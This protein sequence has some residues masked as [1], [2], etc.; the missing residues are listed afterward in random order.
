MS[1]LDAYKSWVE[2]AEE[3][4]IARDPKKFADLAKCVQAWMNAWPDQ[5]TYTD[6]L[7]ASNLYFTCPRE[8]VL[9]YW[10]PT[11]NRSF[12]WK[13]Q[14]MM[15]TGTY[16]H[17]YM[18]DCVLGPL[19]VL[20]GRW[21]NTKETKKV[22]EWEGGIEDY[23][24]EGPCFHPDPE[25]TIREIVDQQPITWKFVEKRVWDE[26]WRIR[27]HLD[28]EVDVGRATWLSDNMTLFK[29]DPMKAM[30]ELWSIPM[31]Q[32]FA[33]ELKTSGNYVL[34]KTN[35]ARDIADYYKTQAVIYQ[36]LTGHENTVFWYLGREQFVS[37]LIVY[38]YDEGWWTTATRKAKIIWRSIKNETLPD[39]GMACKLPTDKRAKSCAHAIPCWASARD[40]DFA[41]YVARGKEL[42]IE[43]GRKLLDLSGK[44]Y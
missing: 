38:P 44:E 15:G 7:R 24:I 32:L 41:E 23:K 33:F 26:H 42:A 28:G 11:R 6:F 30:K 39:A 19:G 18:Q 35:T 21:A 29:R 36:K 37:K 14:L 8:F 12:D 25:R 20:Y 34:E 2:A 16:L 3:R 17:G 1:V 9:N 5:E 43:E 27:G 22:A 10:Q 4:R 13:A 40:F 31:S